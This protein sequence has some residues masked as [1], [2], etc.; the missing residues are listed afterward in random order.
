MKK[1]I[2]AALLCGSAVSSFGQGTV[3]FSNLST[4]LSSPP[5]RLIRFGPWFPPAPPA[6]TPASTNLYPGLVAQLF[7]GASTASASSL[8]AVSSAPGSLRASTS[9]SVGTW[10]G[11]GSR[12]LTGF[13]PGD[14]VNLQVRVWDIRYG[15]DYNTVASG[16]LN[17]GVFCL[18]YSGA[19]G[20][21]YGTSAVFQYT[22]PTN[23][24]PAPSEFNMNNFVGF[25]LN[26][27]GF[28]PEPSAFALAGLGAA[29]LLFRR[30]K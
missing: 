3:N 17:D 11:N 21:W 15:T 19:I 24:T 20:N 6:G 26:P 22:I 14:T 18:T 27:T 1:L 10:F 16:I 4:A 7:Y 5:D 2:V 12:T 28:C 23:P 30:R 9:A 29:L 8:V 25:T 13:N